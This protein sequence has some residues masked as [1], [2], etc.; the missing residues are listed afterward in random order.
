MSRLPASLSVFIFIAASLLMS[1]RVVA[2]E[3]YRYVDD[4]GV[5]CFADRQEAIPAKYR[6]RAVIVGKGPADTRAKDSVEAGTKPTVSTQKKSHPVEDIKATVQALIKNRWVQLFAYFVGFIVAFVLIGKVSSL[7][8]HKQV[9]SV[10]RILLVVG[11]LTYLVS[12]HTQ[13]IVGLFASLKE[14]VLGVTHEVDEK[15]KATE[16]LL[17]NAPGSEKY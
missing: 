9:G 10:I 6:G 13:E 7:L 17:K 16:D 4:N 14:E 3:I 12:L 1:V 11:L 8:N 5:T 2:A 15:N